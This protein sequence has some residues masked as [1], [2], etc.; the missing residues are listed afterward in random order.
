MPH[1]EKLQLPSCLTMHSLYK[2]C[3]ESLE[4]QGLEAVSESHFY[5]LWKIHFNKVSIQKVTSNNK[6]GE[7]VFVLKFMNRPI[8]A[9]LSKFK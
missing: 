1:E 3:K 8:F 6:I 5:S 9:V 7:L 4:A 2:L